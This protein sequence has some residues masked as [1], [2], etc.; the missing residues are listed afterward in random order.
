VKN[1]NFL[2]P[3]NLMEAVNLLNNLGDRARILA[4]GTD[5]LVQMKKGK[6]RPENLINL[7]KI[8]GLN[9]I[10]YTPDGLKV[11]SLVSIGR[12]A[13]EAIIREKYPVLAQA[14]SG[15]GSPQVRTRATIGGNLTNASPAADTAPV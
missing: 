3:K 14:A 5:L 12:L 2:E 11:G 10:E 7:K 9:Q 6:A 1:F 8:P 13:Q 4:G 15:L